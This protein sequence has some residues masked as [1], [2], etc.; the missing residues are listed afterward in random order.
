[1]KLDVGVGELILA[2]QNLLQQWGI[3]NTIVSSAHFQNL[4]NGG[5]VSDGVVDGF[6]FLHTADW[7][8]REGGA[9]LSSRPFHVAEREFS[10]PLVTLARP[11]N[12]AL[13]M[14]PLQPSNSRKGVRK[15][16]FQV[17]TC[18]L[19]ILGAMLTPKCC[20]QF[21]IFETETL[22][23]PIYWR[24]MEHWLPAFVFFSKCKIR[25]YN[26][27]HQRLTG[28]KVGSQPFMAGSWRC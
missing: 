10:E 16:W 24:R 3:G 23:V 13:G 11:R 1:M 15:L 8:E 14:R 2:P 26:S 17:R 22:I 9:Q 6:F 20:V 25:I 27:I 28:A 5:L 12:S 4:V 7:E 21:N 19:K 18:W